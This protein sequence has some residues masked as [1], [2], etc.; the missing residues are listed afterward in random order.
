MK[1]R[2]FLQKSALAAAGAAL[3]SGVFQPET[4]VA[5]VQAAGDR[6]TASLKNLDAHQGET[7]LKMARQLYPHGSCG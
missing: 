5:D 1:R 7:L 3:A 6:W 4:A 2:E